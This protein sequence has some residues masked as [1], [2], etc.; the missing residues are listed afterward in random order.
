MKFFKSIFLTL[1][2]GLVSFAYVD[3]DE[4]VVKN[5]TLLYPK[6]YQDYEFQWSAGAMLTTMPKDWVE[7]AIRAPLFTFNFSFGL[8]EN[9]SVLADA[10][11]LFVANQIRLGPRWGFDYGDLAFNIGYDVGYVFGQ[12]EQFGFTN[13]VHGWMNYPN[14]SIGTNIDDL[15]FT[16]QGELMIMTSSSVTTDGIEIANNGDRVLGGTISLYLEQKLWGN[17]V[18]LFGLKNNIT[19]FYYPAWAVF[20]TFDRLYWIP[21]IH[22]GVVL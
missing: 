7:T 15:F 6:N 19:K 16:L 12:L 1:F 2:I 8:P 18:F 21:Q 22:M 10:E 14:I 20:T 17:H 11:I 9:F 3:A 13:S 4:S 5:H